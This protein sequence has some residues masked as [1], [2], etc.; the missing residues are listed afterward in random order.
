MG[1]LDGY[2]YVVLPVP[3]KWKMEQR[4]K[5]SCLRLPC[6][7]WCANKFILL[8]MQLGLLSFLLFWER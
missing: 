2:I 4:K 5:Q 1:V 7:E 6:F 8:A 3:E